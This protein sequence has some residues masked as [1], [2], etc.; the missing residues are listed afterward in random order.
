MTI[1]SATPAHSLILIMDSKSKNV[2]LTLG[3][4][5]FGQTDTC[6]AVGCR[7]E[8]DGET[9]ISTGL[10]ECL[11]GFRSKQFIISTESNKIITCDIY[12]AVYLYIECDTARSEIAVYYDDLFEP[13]NIYINATPVRE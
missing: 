10:P 7:S 4:G 3:G 8:V 1:I 12:G 2:P 9:N 5:L 6:I 11:T 13:K